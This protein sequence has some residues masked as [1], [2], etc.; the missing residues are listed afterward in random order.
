MD[1][2]FKSAKKQSKGQTVPAHTIQAPSQSLTE[3]DEDK[4]EEKDSSAKSKT[5]KSKKNKKDMAKLVEVISDSKK[6][7]KS[8]SA[9]GK[10]PPVHQR[11]PTKKKKKFMMM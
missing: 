4:E 11:D 1:S 7:N 6:K 8:E 10:E 5:K 2:I 9:I 3:K